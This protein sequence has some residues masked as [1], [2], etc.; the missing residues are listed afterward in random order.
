MRESKEVHWRGWKEERDGEVIIVSKIKYITYMNTT[1][2][3]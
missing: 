1:R 2:I 3:K